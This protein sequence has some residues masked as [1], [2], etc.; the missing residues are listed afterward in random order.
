VHLPTGR[1]RQGADEEISEG[2]ACVGAAALPLP[3]M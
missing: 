1:G 3:T 2:R